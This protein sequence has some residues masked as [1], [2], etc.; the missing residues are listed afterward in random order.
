[1]KKAI[2]QVCNG[3]AHSNP[4]IDH[5]GVCMPH[6]GEYPT[7]PYCGKKLGATGVSKT[8]CRGCKRYVDMTEPRQYSPAALRALELKKEKLA[9]LKSERLSKALEVPETALDAGDRVELLAALRD[10]Q[11]A[12]G[13]IGSALE[14]KNKVTEFEALKQAY[15]GVMRAN[16]ATTSIMFK[17][18]R[19]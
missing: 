13:K 12:C 11:L 3:D 1:M 8:M 5:C 2:W 4:H 14:A 7:C 18:V 16:R 19:K 17:F 15:E 10:L 6:W 9:I